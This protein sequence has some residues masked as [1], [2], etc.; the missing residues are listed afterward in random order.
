MNIQRPTISNVRPPFSD[1][2]NDIFFAAVS[3]TRMPMLV[4]DPN[5]VDNPIVFV[6]S[7]FLNLTG[8]DVEELMGN[9]CRLLQGPE[10][11]RATISEIRDAIADG[12]EINTEI[13]NY[14]K[15]G[16]SFWN[17]LFISPVRNEA[18]DIVYYFASQLDISRRRDAEEALRQS[19]KME[20]LGQLTGGIAHDF[21]NLLQVMSG[22][23]DIMKLGIEH[24]FDLGRFVMPV[25][26]MRDAITRAS[27]L[28][29]QL[30]AFAR[31]QELRG[32]VINLNSRLA[33][34]RELADNTFGETKA[35]SFVPDP[36]LRNCQLDVS[37]FEVAVLNLLLNARDALQGRDNPQVT[38]RTGNLSLTDR[39]P[40]GFAQL[41]P[42]EYVWVSVSDN[43]VGI[44]PHV[45][46]HVMDPFF[47]TKEEGKG[48]GLGLSMVYGFV[49]QSGG[50]VDIY[51]ERGHG[52]T[53]RLYFPAVAAD[54]GPDHAERRHAD[55]TVRNE[56]ILVVDDRPDVAEV[57][58]IN[59]QQGGYK[60]I[61]AHGAHDALEELIRH[62]E[63]ELLFTDLIMPGGM[64][65]VMLAQEARRRKP[66]LRVLLTTGYADTSIAR[67][68]L[69]GTEFP[70]LHK[71]YQAIELRAAI[72][73]A[74]HNP[75]TDS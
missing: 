54:A 46:A 53:V 38:V 19:Q 64:N 66:L 61:V 45:L 21:N 47:T 57:A 14:R 31:K 75:G 41:T 29:Q 26:R 56:T 59:L 74:L 9:N 43:G 24:K 4:T 72:S 10:T 12:R 36:S 18:G 67:N 16:S 51:S 58:A 6:N 30:L 33:D 20:A 11:S 69:D 32:R 1:H 5:Q 70:V 7:A 42:G 63:V 55:T 49:R 52:T 39:R 17:A 65:G 8:Y 60:T 44:P 3:T 50:A 2:S 73:Q 34:I 37:Q 71:P 13:L 68:D 25:E 28:T 62:P 27:T 15:D 22:Y 23:V 40:I 35:L 48:T